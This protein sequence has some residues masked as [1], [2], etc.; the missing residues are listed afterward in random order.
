MTFNELHY[1]DTPLLIANVWDVPSTKTAEKLNFQAVGTSSA[2][3]AA[4]FGYEDGEQISFSELEYIV[5]RISLNTRL[6]LS[7]DFE[8]GYSRDPKKIVENIKRLAALG[9]VGINFEDSIVE[10]GRQILDADEFATKLSAVSGLLKKERIEI[11][12]NVRVDPFLMGLDNA[13]EE[14]KK[15]IAHYEQAGADGIFTPCIV[16]ESDITEVVQCTTLPLN[17]LCM[18]DLPDFDT[19]TKLGVKRISMGDFPYNQMITNYEASIKN[20]LHEGS[21]KNVF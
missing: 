11:F 13:L 5:K 19:L 16:K 14:T 18:P 9:V 3:V 1:Q 10:N 20:I 21:F 15:R 2:A 8:A 7:V 17:V 6:P 12:I 4:I